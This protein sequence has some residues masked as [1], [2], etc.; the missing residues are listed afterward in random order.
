[1]VLENTIEKHADEKARALGGFT[2][3][4]V[5]DGRRG[6]PDRLVVLPGGVILFLELKRP[7][8]GVVDTLQRY[9]HNNIRKLGHAAHYAKTT[10]EIDDIYNEAM[11]RAG[12]THY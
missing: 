2:V 12:R 6:I 7:R 1:M 4:L 3:K 11:V 9:W 5:P 8:G 10:G